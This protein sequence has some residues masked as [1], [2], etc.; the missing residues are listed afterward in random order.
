[1]RVLII[2]FILGGVVLS[3]CGGGGGDTEETKALKAVMAFQGDDPKASLP[4]VGQAYQCSITVVSQPLLLPTPQ[5][6]VPG[7]CLWKLELQSNLWFATF[8]EAWSCAD[9]SADVASYP[10]CS[11]PN[12]FH[13]WQYLVD[14]L[15]HV[16]PLQDDG[17]FAPDMK[18]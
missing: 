7:T 17:N 13:T 15:Q 8:S 4:P 11:P 1:M 10:P 16:E 12:G 2:A 9:F 5:P 14:H 18:R 3:A 6:G